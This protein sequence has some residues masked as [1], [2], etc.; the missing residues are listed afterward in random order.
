ML[1][2]VLTG[3]LPFEIQTDQ[4]RKTRVP[5]EITDE[6]VRRIA[7][8]LMRVVSNN[9]IERPESAAQ[10]RQELQNAL[11]AI[12]E[13]VVEQQ[14][15]PQI[16]SWVEHVRG[17]YRNSNTGNA[18]NRGLDTQFVRDTY[19][20][21][22]LD[23]ILLPMIFVHRPNAV[24]LT[25]NPGDGKTAFLEQVQQELRARKAQRQGEPDASG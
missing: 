18:D 5:P 24:F 3:Y 9:P 11:L 15:A 14:L 20:P 23:E 17:L 22:A 10:M 7:R 21:T 12:E 16:N 13:P 1:F 8:V 19:V 25:G 2:K 6:K 4:Q